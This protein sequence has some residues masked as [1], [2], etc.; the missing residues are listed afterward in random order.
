MLVKKLFEEITFLGGIMFY[1][2]VI[3]YFYALGKDQYTKILITSLMVIYALTVLIRAVYFKKRPRAEQYRSFMEKID[4]SSFPSVHAARIT[5]LFLL[6]S[7]TYQSYLAVIF[8]GIVV[9]AVCYS[10]I[11]LKKHYIIDIISGILM[12][13]L[14]FLGAWNIIPRVI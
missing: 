8:G 11:Y 13:A 3:V 12:G 2:I 4:A 7:Y 10:R 5:V 1:L 9:L 14:V 6:F